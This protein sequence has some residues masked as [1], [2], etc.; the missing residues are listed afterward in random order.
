[1]VLELVAHANGAGVRVPPELALLGKTLLN[2]DQVVRSLAPDLDVNAATSR[3]LASLVRKRMWRAVTPATVFRTLSESKEL[4][5]QLPARVNQILSHLAENDLRINV[6][7]IDE[8]ELIKGFQKIAN[9]ISGGLLVAALIVGAALMMRVQ[10]AF[11][12]FGY[13]GLAMIFFL[14]AAAGGC[15]MLWSILSGDR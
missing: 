15:A 8:T 9:R 10:T 12:L 1:V 13:P 4:V 11:T 7:A 2:L 14:L 6:D 5:E 3:H